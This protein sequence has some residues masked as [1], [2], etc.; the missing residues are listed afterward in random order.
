[1]KHGWFSAYV[2]KKAGSGV[3]RVQNN[4][5]KFPTGSQCLGDKVLL[6]E[7]GF[8]PNTQLVPFLWHLHIS[9]LCWLG[10]LRSKRTPLT[11]IH[12][13]S[14]VSHG[15][16]GR[17]LTRSQSNKR[18]TEADDPTPSSSFSTYIVVTDP[19]SAEQRKGRISPGKNIIIFSLRPFT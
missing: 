1:M 14:T 18:D 13:S 4:R 11:G 3:G 10:S 12:E 8:V 19:S 2:A 7:E 5:V 17:D 15:E 9:K 16:G 6:Q